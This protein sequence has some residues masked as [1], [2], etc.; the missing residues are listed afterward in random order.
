MHFNNLVETLQYRAEHTPDNISYSFL[1]DGESIGQQFTYGQLEM[2]ARTI[3]ATLQQLTQKGD[4]ALMLYPSGLDF[5][6]AFM[7]CQFS[8][9]VAVPALR[10]MA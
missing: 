3:G 10:L 6:A 9:V 7:G 1:T 2:Q 4:R 8:G 5:V